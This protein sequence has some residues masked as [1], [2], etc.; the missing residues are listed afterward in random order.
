MSDFGGECARSGSLRYNSVTSMADDL[1]HLF[2]NRIAELHQSSHDTMDAFYTVRASMFKGGVTIPELE[3]KAM[4][5]QNLMECLEAK[6]NEV[7]ALLRQLGLDAVTKLL[8]TIPIYR[9]LNESQARFIVLEYR[10]DVRLMFYWM[11]PQALAVKKTMI[12]SALS[13][14]KKARVEIC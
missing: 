7:E 13:Q 10:E 9:D 2:T 1:L 11:R 14:I 5:L 4:E 3:A 12:A 6:G 8:I